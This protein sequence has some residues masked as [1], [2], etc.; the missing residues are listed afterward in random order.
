MLSFAFIKAVGQTGYLFYGIYCQLF[1]ICWL[2]TSG[3]DMFKETSKYF[4]KLFVRLLQK[5]LQ[6][7]WV[8][9][10][11]HQWALTAWECVMCTGGSVIHTAHYPNEH[12]SYP[13]LRRRKL[14]DHWSSASS[15]SQ[16]KT[17]QS[18]SSPTPTIQTLVT[19]PPFTDSHQMSLNYCSLCLLL[20]LD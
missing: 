19:R 7:A 9:W 11:R 15:G 8:D 1:S 17:C 6:Y 3:W 5:V 16:F 12:H 20:M 18:R 13:I 10:S 14:C 2:Y 4:R